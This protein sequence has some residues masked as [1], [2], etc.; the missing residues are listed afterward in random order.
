MYK[1]EKLRKNLWH[2]IRIGGIRAN[3]WFSTYINKYRHTCLNIERSKCVYIHTHNLTDIFPN[4]LQRRPGNTVTPKATSA[5]GTQP[6]LSQRG[7]TSKRVRDALYRE[8]IKYAEDG[9]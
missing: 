2:W 9:P 5:P 6:L 8:V 3:S 1:R 7:G 4:F